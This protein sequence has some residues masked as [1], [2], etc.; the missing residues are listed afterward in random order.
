MYVV[1]LIRDDVILSTNYS[2][3]SIAKTLRLAWELLGGIPQAEVCIRRHGDLVGFLHT[4]FRGE[5]EQA[6]YLVRRYFPGDKSKY[7]MCM[8]YELN[9]RGP[10]FSGVFA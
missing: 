6:E 7:S 3:Q 9:P 1:T 4:N 5:L 8:V 10:L 2:R